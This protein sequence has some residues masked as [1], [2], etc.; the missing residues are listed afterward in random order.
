MSQ[1]AP[2]GIC[3]TQGKHWTRSSAASCWALG[4]NFYFA[5]RHDSSS[6]SNTKARSCPREFAC[7]ALTKAIVSLY[8]SCFIPFAQGSTERIKACKSLFRGKA[9]MKAEGFHGQPP[10]TQPKDC[11]PHSKVAYCVKC[12]A[13]QCSHRWALGLSKEPRMGTGSAGMCQ[14]PTAP[15]AYRTHFNEMPPLLS[16]P[17]P[18]WM[19]A[20]RVT[21]RRLQ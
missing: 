15:C 16:P 21:L 12:H 8:K 11:F 9:K 7:S 18:K 1:N 6:G 4:D 14:G 5:K 20:R 2:R 13:G 3:T 17:T 19:P 10:H